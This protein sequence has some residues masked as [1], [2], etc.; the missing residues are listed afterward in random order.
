MV[1]DVK[2]NTSIRNIPKENSPVLFRHLLKNSVLFKFKT[3]INSSK[4]ILR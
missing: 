2:K 4:K 3:K 1:T